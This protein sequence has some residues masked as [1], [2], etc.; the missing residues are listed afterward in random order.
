V[1]DRALFDALRQ[2]DPSAGAK[3]VLRAN[4]DAIVHVTVDDHGSFVDVDTPDEYQRLLR[5]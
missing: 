2:A 1:I 5:S 4:A 3:S